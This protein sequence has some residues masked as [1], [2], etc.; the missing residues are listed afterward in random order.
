M[1]HTHWGFPLGPFSVNV[2]TTGCERASAAAMLAR[3]TQV[4]S[5]QW[6]EIV[7]QLVEQRTFNP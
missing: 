2:L 6:F 5:S 4:L 7:A 1:I 3:L